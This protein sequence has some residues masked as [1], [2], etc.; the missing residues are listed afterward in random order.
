[1]PRSRGSEMANQ[2]QSPRVPLHLKTTACSEANSR[3]TNDRSP[4]QND[5]RSP[6]SLLHGKKVLKVADLEAKLAQAQEEMKKLKDQLA[7][8]EEAKRDVQLELEE[9]KKLFPVTPPK[10]ASP[11]LEE[12]EKEKTINM[13]E[14]KVDEEGPHEEAV[15]ALLAEEDSI[16]YP[17]TDVF[18]VTP[19]KMQ[20]EGSQAK[21]E[22]ERGA[23]VQAFLEDE[24]EKKVEEQKEADS[25]M[26]ELRS[27]ITE[28]T[29]ELKR[30]LLENESLRNEAEEA[31]SDSVAAK[32]KAEEMATKFAGAM[33]ELGESRKALEQIRE[34][35][36]AQDRSKASLEAEMN[37][38][39][40]QTEQWRKAAEAAASVLAAGDGEDLNGRRVSER[41]R[42]MENHH[43]DY[44]VSASG[45]GW[46]PA[47]AGGEME[48]GMSGGKRRSSG[49]IRMFGDLWKKKTQQK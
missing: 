40:V 31:K 5:H 15:E 24:A 35:L 13:E 18:E 21:E 36:E 9:T 41:C 17:T 10:T 2:R 30:V 42:S 26:A 23:A 6:R 19:T 48:D 43:R 37:R 27:T 46:S 7:L 16:N 14:E 3:P 32:D 28:K 39:R 47:V 33:Q 34:K 20:G 45:G 8:A 22:G 12:E 49:G 11:E 44:D 4:K 25:K 38:L 1:M 29:V